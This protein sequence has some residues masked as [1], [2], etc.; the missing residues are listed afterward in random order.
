MWPQRTLRPMAARRREAPQMK[1]TIKVDTRAIAR[2]IS[3]LARKQIPFAIS[4]AINST[5]QKVIAAETDALSETFDTPRAFTKSAFTM[6]SSFGG[7]YAT[8]RDPTAVIVAKPIQAAYLAPS[9]FNETQSLGQGRR[10]RT[11][12]DIKT[13][14]GGNIA[15]GAIAQLL[16]EPD[17]F[18]GVVH[19]VNG[20]WQ[21]PS[22]PRPKGAPR[23]RIKSNTTGRL[24]LLVAFTRPVHVK[25]QLGYLERARS[26]FEADWSREF[27]AALSKAIATAR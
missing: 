21:R 25:T 22:S 23:R 7:K 1:L 4:Q 5:A 16:A 20:L 26:V 3:S 18:L 9:E 13:G 6:A 2:E 12:V 15:K 19:G 14:A 8:K 17:V 27:D 24:K 11:P 10:I